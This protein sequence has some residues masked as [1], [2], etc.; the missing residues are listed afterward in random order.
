MVIADC[1]RLKEKEEKK[2][3]Q[4]AKDKK[5]A[6]EKEETAEKNIDSKPVCTE[7]GSGLKFS[8]RLPKKN[9]VRFWCKNQDCDYKISLPSSK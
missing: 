5:S 2:K 3:A 7:C 1:G 8:K 4:K 9:L 6:E